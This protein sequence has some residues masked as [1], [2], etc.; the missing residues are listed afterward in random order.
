MDS[1][2]IC[3]PAQISENP[4]QKSRIKDSVIIVRVNVDKVSH[5]AVY[6]CLVKLFKHKPNIISSRFS[7]IFVRIQKNYPIARRVTEC[8][9]TR[10]RKIIKPI[11][12]ENFC[13]KTFCNIYSS[14]NRSRID[15][16]N[17]ISGIM[18]TFKR[19]TQIFF[20]IFNNVTN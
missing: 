20:F 8:N 15:D 1:A 7:K 16:N 13:T 6:F 17:F 18:Q 19:L 12:T 3:K 10:R 11:F 5:Q 9:I 2:D 14:V 4:Q